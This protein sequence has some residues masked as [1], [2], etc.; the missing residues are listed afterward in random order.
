MSTPTVMP[1]L[2]YRNA[3]EA[4]HAGQYDKGASWS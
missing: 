4:I 2:I 3:L 1:G